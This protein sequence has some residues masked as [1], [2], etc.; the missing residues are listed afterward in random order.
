MFSVDVNVKMCFLETVMNKY[1]M[2]IYGQNLE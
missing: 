2:N 1:K